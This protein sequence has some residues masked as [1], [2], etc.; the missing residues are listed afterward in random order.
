[1]DEPERW[2]WTFDALFDTYDL[3]VS[4]EMADALVAD[5]AFTGVTIGTR[6]SLTL[7]GTS[8][9]ALGLD[10]RSGS[11]LPQTTVGRLP[12]SESEV[13][14]GERTLRDLGQQVGDEIIATSSDG[15]S[16]RL[17]I[18]GSV[19]LPPALALNETF[20]LGNGA[21]VTTDGLK[22]MSPGSA[23]SFALVDTKAAPTRANLARIDASYPSTQLNGPQLPNEIGNYD[24]VRAAPLILAGF[25]GLL[26]TFVLAHALITTVRARR[27][28]L[29]VLKTIGFS[30]RQVS[31]SVTWQA[32]TLAGVGL[33][34]ALVP[35]VA[36]T[37]LIWGSF[38]TSLG[39]SSPAV[40][41][42]LGVAA[43]LVGTFVVA[44]VVGALPARTA[45]RIPVADALRDE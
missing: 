16:K 34:V 14:L 1:M 15:V 37:R 45:S 8:V 22:A 13:A 36:A 32:T 24:G 40:V 6:G 42:V 28:E 3:G 21:V 38:E 27:R 10:V 11:A 39:L 30:R 25:L 29:A 23:P 9:A 33:V 5:P 44:A 20:A 17:R 18:V 12:D 4:A 2:G 35:S 41:P 19:V 43:I 7:Q 26:A 31:S